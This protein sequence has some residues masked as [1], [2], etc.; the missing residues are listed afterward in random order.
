MWYKSGF[1]SGSLGVIELTGA[2]YDALSD[3]EK[4]KD[5][6]YVITDRASYLEGVPEVGGATESTAGVAGI[7]PAPAAGD[8]TKFLRGDGTW[9]NAGGG[10]SSPNTITKSQDGTTFIQ[11]FDD[12]SVNTI[13]KT[14]TGFRQITRDTSGT[15]I[16]DVT[17]TINEDGSI[18][19]ENTVQHK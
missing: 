6:I 13:T 19:T 9:A 7:V 15:I 5:V 8:Q 11:T 18:R 1:G 3:E 2:E 12:G 16:S 14:S 17:T 4:E 10:S